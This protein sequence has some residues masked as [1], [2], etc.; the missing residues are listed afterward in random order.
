MTQVKAQLV[1]TKREPLWAIV[2]IFALG[3]VMLALLLSSPMLIRSFLYQPFN[4]PSGSMKPT[5]LVGDYFFVSK[6]AYGYGPYTWPLSAP[7]AA[8][9][10]W[11]AEPARGDVVVF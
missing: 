3:F 2:G 8:G 7:P 11:G 6:Y 4:S 10:I 9:R 1:G 5:L